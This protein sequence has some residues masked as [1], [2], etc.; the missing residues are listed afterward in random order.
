MVFLQHHSL[1]PMTVTVNDEMVD[2]RV[3]YGLS[4]R[5]ISV[6]LPEGVNYKTGDHLLVM[7]RNPAVNVERAAVRFGLGI[8]QRLRLSLK[9]GSAGAI[10]I[11]SDITVNY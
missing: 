4:K 2:T 6:N 7:P 8:Q 1:T 5:H 11:N 3:D 10:P 9:H